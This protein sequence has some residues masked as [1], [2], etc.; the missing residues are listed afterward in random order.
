MRRR[1]Q[2]EHIFKLL[3]ISEFNTQKE[4]EEQLALYL[5]DIENLEES[6]AEYRQ[7]CYHGLTRSCRTC[8]IRLWNLSIDSSSTLRKHCAVRS[9]VT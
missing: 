5:A 1:E 3:F 9:F 4:M 8:L 7:T 6:E 2:R